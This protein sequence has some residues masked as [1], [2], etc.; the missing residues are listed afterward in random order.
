VGPF[1]EA[2]LGK[3]VQIPADRQLA[4]VQGIAQLIDIHRPLV[5][6]PGQN[7]LLT[8]CRNVCH[9]YFLIVFERIYTIHSKTFT[10]QYTMHLSPSDDVFAS[11]LDD[12][13]KARNPNI[14]KLQANEGLPPHNQVR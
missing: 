4:D 11:L 5:L 3:L 12:V 1:D 10:C 8:A 9:E 13:H 6:N 7:V 14:G 2:P